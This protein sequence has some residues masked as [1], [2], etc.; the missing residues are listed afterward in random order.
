VTVL[1]R[2]QTGRRFDT[3]RMGITSESPHPQMFSNDITPLRLIRIFGLG[4][5]DRSRR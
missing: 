2:Y 3:V 1:E 5:V 4:L